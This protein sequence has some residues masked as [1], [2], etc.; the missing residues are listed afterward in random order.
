MAGNYRALPRLLFLL[1]LLLTALWK[2]C[3]AQTAAAVSERN[4]K[5]FDA[6][7]GLVEK[8]YF[9]PKFNGA[10]WARA[11]VT[12]RPQAARASGEGE[13]YAVLNRMLTDLH[14]SHTWAA[15]P[16]EVKRE[17]AHQS[18]DLGFV[19]KVIEGRLVM[20][21]IRKGSSADKAGIRPGWILT[22]WADGAVDV[23]HLSGFAL[24]DGDAVRLTFLDAQDCERHVRMVARPFTNLPEQ[25]SRVL[26]GGVLYIR[27]ESFYTEGTGNWFAETLVRNS[28]AR[29]CIIDLRGNWGGYFSELKRAV[30][31]LYAKAIQFG[32]FVERDGERLPF[33]VPGAGSAAFGGAV[34]ILIDEGSSSAAECFAAA[35]QESGRGKVVGRQS[36]GSVL[37]NT[38][39]QLPD[40]GQ[41]NISIRDYITRNGYRIEG[42]GVKPDLTVPLALA[43]LRLNVDADLERA[44]Q[45][46]R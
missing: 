1:P 41:L 29:A 33:R 32:N 35:V 17:K 37:N 22:H 4:L 18:T 7:W 45:L 6:M 25:F 23:S 44:L 36:S 5:V 13:L 19:G 34:I 11:R 16:S 31:P 20:T 40:G 43:T 24:G 12:Y 27:S 28:S 10:D 9:D 46:I 42:R 14:D 2:P 38:Q 30:E 26:A 3:S 39:E 21:H 15:S 8:R